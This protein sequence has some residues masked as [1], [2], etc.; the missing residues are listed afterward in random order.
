MAFGVSSR[1]SVCVARVDDGNF[2]CVLGSVSWDL[3][4][5]GVKGFECCL[6][7][8]NAVL[9]KEAEATVLIGSAVLA[10]LVGMCVGMK[11]FV[12]RAFC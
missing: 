8:R 10:S 7:C 9:T 3:C 6:C 12:R 4:V 2:T 11:K 5:F 1:R